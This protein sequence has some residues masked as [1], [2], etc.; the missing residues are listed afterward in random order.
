MNIEQELPLL[1]QLL[2]D[3][4]TVLGN[5]LTGYKNH[6]YRV[7]HY[8]F[9]LQDCDEEDKQKLIIAGVFHDLGAWTKN[10]MDYLPPSA[11]LAKTYLNQSNLSAWSEE[12]EL[13]I[14]M[15][16]KLTPFKD[17]RFPLVEAFRKSD[18]IDVT[19]GNFRYG[20]PKNY[21]DAVKST[22]P[23]CGFYNYANQSVVEWIKKNPF[24]P[25]PMLKW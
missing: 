1:E 17:P 22:F 19:R 8:C 7:I 23:P 11:E 10:T 18:F 6:I 15:H 20:I 3:W 16:H 21:I 24:N 4:E 9:W 12:I 13:M 14:T 2:T 25:L 5:E